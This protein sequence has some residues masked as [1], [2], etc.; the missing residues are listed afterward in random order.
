MRLSSSSYI[1]EWDVM[2]VF[3]RVTILA[4]LLRVVVI[5]DAPGESFLAAT[6][7]WST[8]NKPAFLTS[9]IISP[10]ISSDDMCLAG[11]GKYL[12]FDV[13][14]DFG[15]HSND[16]ARFNPI[17]QEFSNGH[18]RQKRARSSQSPRP[19]ENSH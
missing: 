2:K 16:D 8:L 13:I 4:D 3:V 6:E 9:I 10:K 5:N 18:N 11:H 19:S 12:L 15:S 14:R 1:V 17:M 7:T